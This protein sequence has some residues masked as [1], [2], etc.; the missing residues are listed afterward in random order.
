MTDPSDDGQAGV[1]EAE[2]VC[3]PQVFVRRHRDEVL[4]AWFWPGGSMWL[5]PGFGVPVEVTSSEF[6]TSV[7]L[8]WARLSVN[9]GAT[10][11]RVETPT[12]P[13][14]FELIR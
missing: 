10:G 3:V 14:H 9:P 8:D 13:A 11:L 4:A 12:G 1:T 7:E 5:Q 6:A 2:C